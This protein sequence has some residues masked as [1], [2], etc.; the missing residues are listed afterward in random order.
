MAPPPTDI[1]CE[2]LELVATGDPA[3]LKA[4]SL[5]S[6]ELRTLVKHRWFRVLCVQLRRC[7]LDF[8]RAGSPDL[9]QP[10]AFPLLRYSRLAEL[11][12][13]HGEQIAQV[14]HLH[15]Y[16]HTFRREGQAAFR[17]IFDH[18]PRIETLWIEHEDW[19]VVSPSLDGLDRLQHLRELSLPMTYFTVRTLLTRTKLRGVTHLHLAPVRGDDRLDT[20]ALD[21]FPSLTHLGFGMPSA[22]P[23]V[24]RAAEYRTAERR[25]TLGVLV[26][27]EPTEPLFVHPRVLY[28]RYLALSDDQ[29]W[30]KRAC[31]GWNPE[32]PVCEGPFWD[33]WTFFDAVMAA[34]SRG[35]L[36]ATDVPMTNCV[37]D[38]WAD[39][40]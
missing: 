14:R 5:V 35:K 15:M 1:L 38:H 9:Q 34:R 20:A 7:R 2:I 40:R 8:S 27:G 18:C 10:L 17:R 33:Q 39:L 21:A 3:S 29:D 4:L 36:L 6:K 31:P 22:G 24:Q 16:G 28:L 25:T 32:Q 12:S 23:C 11:L 26:R 37:R 30:L 19:Y 13:T